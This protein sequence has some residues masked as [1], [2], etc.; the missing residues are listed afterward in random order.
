M[1]LVFPEASVRGNTKISPPSPYP[2]WT[3]ISAREK[4]LAWNNPATW[5][6]AGHS[7]SGGGDQQRTGIGTLSSVF[8]AMPDLVTRASLSSS[9]KLHGVMVVD[10]AASRTSGSS[11]ID[12]S[13]AV[14]RHWRAS[15]LLDVVALSVAAAA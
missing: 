3:P 15:C 13:V 12:T 14:V 7:F 10:T 8:G 6:A 2:P 11:E 5:P 1:Q 4:E 9:G